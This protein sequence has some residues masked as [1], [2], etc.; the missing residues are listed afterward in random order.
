ML[1]MLWTVGV[2]STLAAVALWAT[3]LLS[4][5]EIA[6]STKKTTWE[7]LFEGSCLTHCV[8]T[9]QGAHESAE[10]HTAR[11]A[12]AVALDMKTFPVKE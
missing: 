9:T 4:P 2:C 5:L 7:T 3:L 11:H 10:E 8:E 6:V 12:T 1:A